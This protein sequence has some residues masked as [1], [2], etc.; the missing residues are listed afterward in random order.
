M[1]KSHRYRLENIMAVYSYSIRTKIIST[2]HKAVV[3]TAMTCQSRLRIWCTNLSLEIAAPTKQR[4]PHTWQLSQV[5]TGSRGAVPFKQP[6]AYHD[7]TKLSLSSQK[8]YKIMRMKMFII[9]V[10]PKLNTYNVKRLKLSG[11][12]AYGRSKA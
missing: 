8:S 3:V 12:Q 11:R 7:A 1:Q 9:W 4:S 6:C 2:L 5:Y 10:N